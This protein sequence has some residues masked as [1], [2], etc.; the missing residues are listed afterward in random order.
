MIKCF[1]GVNL[2]VPPGMGLDPGEVGV[3]KDYV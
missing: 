1:F 3:P 2:E